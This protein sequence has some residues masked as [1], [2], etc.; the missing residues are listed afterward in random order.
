MIYDDEAKRERRRE[1]IGEADYPVGFGKTPPATKF[2][3]GKSGNPKGRPKKALGIKTMVRKAAESARRVS[4]QGENE[5]VRSTSAS[6]RSPLHQG[7]QGRPEGDRDFRQAVR[8]IRPHRGN[9]Q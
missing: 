9:R 4:S 3:P 7:E 1:K 8:S 6:P 2:K 5:E